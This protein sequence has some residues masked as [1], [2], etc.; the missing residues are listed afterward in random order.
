MGDVA[1]IIVSAF[2]TASIGV[3]VVCAAH[4]TITESCSPGVSI[5]VKM[6]PSHTSHCVM[7][8]IFHV[9]TH[10]IRAGDRR[11][12]ATNHEDE[13]DITCNHNRIF[14]TLLSLHIHTLHFVR[15]TDHTTSP[16]T[17]TTHAAIR[18]FSIS[19]GPMVKKPSV[20]RVGGSDGF[21]ITLQSG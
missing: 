20:R 2:L 13:Y 17:A 1:L 16:P 19:S 5:P 14:I 15:Y 12:N 4:C 6:H 21:W 11:Y 10:R 9:T 3:I 8:S 7:R 18:S